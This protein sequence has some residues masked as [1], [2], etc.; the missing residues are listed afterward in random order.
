MNKISILICF[1]IIS[2]NV[3]SKIVCESTVT[4]SIERTDII[5]KNKTA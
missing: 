5:K 4:N 3:Y 2:T 1:F